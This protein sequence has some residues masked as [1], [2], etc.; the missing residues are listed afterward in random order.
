[1][2]LPYLHLIRITIYFLL[3]YIA[4]DIEVIYLHLRKFFPS[5]PC[6]ILFF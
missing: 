5:M 3:P 4:A 6:I 1:M 2:L